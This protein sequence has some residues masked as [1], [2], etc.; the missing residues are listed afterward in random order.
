MSSVTSCVGAVT[1]SVVIK[2][3]E[4]GHHCDNFQLLSR[5]F[6]L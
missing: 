5:F 4:K 3:H 2:A 6:L 1:V